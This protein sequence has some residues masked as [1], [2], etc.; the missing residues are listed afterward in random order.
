MGFLALVDLCII[1]P[2]FVETP[3][4]RGGAREEQHFRIGGELSH[5]FNVT[6]LSPFHGCYIRQVAINDHF[7]INQVFFP[8]KKEYPPKSRTVHKV[9]LF[10]MILY[11]FLVSLKVVCMAKKGLRIVIVTDILSGIF[12][13]FVAKILG[14]KVIFS[15]GNLWPWVESRTTPKKLSFIQK[16]MYS[17]MSLVGRQ[18]GNFA[19]CIRTQSSSIKKG[20]IRKG[21]AKDKIV[22]IDAGVDTNQFRPTSCVHSN[23]FTVGFVGRLSDEKGAS[24]LLEICKRMETASSA[25]DFVV[26]GEGFYKKDLKLLKNVKFVGWISRT[27][28]PEALCNID[29][30]LFLQRDLS[31]TVLEA[32]ASGKVIIAGCIGELPRVI[33]HMK[34]GILC[35]LNSDSYLNAIELVHENPSLVTTL[36][37]K[38][39][40]TAE[41]CFD[42]TIIGS[43]WI[44]LCK[45]LCTTT[46]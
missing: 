36:S 24:L 21:I 12:P 40:E 31:I 19:S 1:S 37:N 4:S 18:L 32:L 5:C 29:V 9:S 25:T 6:L 33:K 30:I 42:W 8:S 38:A 2:G 28:L 26:Y 23:D 34:N 39:R 44:S 13:I 41:N 14:L 46:R 43:R 20:M 10:F 45:Q 7:Q 15:E 16:L 27:D 11:S 35:S 3:T 22:V 17:F